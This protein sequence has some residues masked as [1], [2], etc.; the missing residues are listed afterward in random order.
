MKRVIIAFVVLIALAAAGAGGWY[1]WQ[2][3]QSR[4]PPDIASGNGRIEADEIDID[5]KFPGRIAEL[6]ADEGDIVKAGQ[7]VA[8]MD[9]RDLEATLQSH[10]AQVRQAQKT[11][12]EARANLQKS[13]EKL[14]RQELDRTTFLLQKGY[15]TKELFDQRQQQMGGASAT[16]AAATARIGQAEHALDA[17]RHDVELDKVNIAD[18]TLV[19]PRDGR[20]QYR[21][22]NIGEVLPAGGKV[23]AMLD[24]S[25]VY[26][27]VYLPTVEAGKIRL[28]ADARI[29][30]DSYPDRPLPAKVTFLATEAQFT[31]KA[32]ETKNERDKLM[33]RVRV[34]I[35]ADLLRAHADAVRTGL[36]G[37]AYVP[38]AP[39]VAWPEWLKSVAAK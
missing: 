5:T 24:T 6:L 35:D 37:V 2:Q 17:A 21:I 31:P 33:F 25:Y 28:G 16:V 3:Q 32:V 13:Q 36:P 10:E 20:I 22:S 12:D 34:R 39:N 7:V 38:L 23:F 18:N 19:A 30:L 29:L 9:T 26:M 14:A 15:A 8:R 11:L 4:L 1:W 27:D